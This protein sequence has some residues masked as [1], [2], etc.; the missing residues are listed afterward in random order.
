VCL[1]SFVTPAK[2]VLFT[3]PGPAQ[4]FEPTEIRLSKTTVNQYL[5]NISLGRLRS[6]QRLR[7]AH[8]QCSQMHG[9]DL[10]T[11]RYI[12]NRARQF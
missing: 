6:V 5:S 8:C 12:G 3:L 1:F 2:L 9:L 10:P 11:P 4:V 7:E